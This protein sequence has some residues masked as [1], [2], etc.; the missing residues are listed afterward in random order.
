MDS[1]NLCLTHLKVTLD[2]FGHNTDNWH[3]FCI[4]VWLY[5]SVVLYRFGFMWCLLRLVLVVLYCSLTPTHAPLTVHYLFGNNH[6]QKG[7]PWLDSNASRILNRGHAIMF[8]NA[9]PRAHYGP[10]YLDPFLGPPWALMPPGVNIRFPKASCI[11]A[12]NHQFLEPPDQASEAVSARVT[13][14][15]WCACDRHAHL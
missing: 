1:C 3:S 11:L 10:C 2:M 9:L 13:S 8:V 6:E 14:A 12:S 7:W 4:M 5:F 15:S